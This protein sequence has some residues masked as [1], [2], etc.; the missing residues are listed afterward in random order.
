MI[1]TVHLKGYLFMYP[2]SKI[3]LQKCTADTTGQ[4]ALSLTS[5]LSTHTSQC[6]ATQGIPDLDV[7]FI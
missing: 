2:V 4:T 6:L 1:R 7:V 5:F 3:G